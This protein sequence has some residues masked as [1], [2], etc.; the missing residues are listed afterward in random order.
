LALLDR[1][2]ILAEA[3]IWYDAIEELPQAIEA[4]PNAGL[5]RS[6]RRSLLAQVK[7]QGVAVHEQ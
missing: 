4:V 6:Q 3:G 5:L 7:L 2:R 1:A